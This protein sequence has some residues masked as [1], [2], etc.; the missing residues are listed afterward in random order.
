[1]AVKWDEVN[2]ILHAIHSQLGLWPG[3]VR[4]IRRQEIVLARILIGHS[5]LTHSF[6]LRKRK[7]PQCTVC[8]GRLTQLTVKHILFDCVDLLKPEID[9][10]M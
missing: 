2:K 7:P 1:M 9:I 4:I 3:G 10:L 5:N 8:Y 6:L